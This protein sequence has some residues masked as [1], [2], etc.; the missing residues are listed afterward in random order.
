MQYF[1]AVG[2]AIQENAATKKKKVTQLIVQ[3]VKT[4]TLIATIIYYNNNHL[5]LASL[6]YQNLPM[7][8][9]EIF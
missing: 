3:R 8:Y 7:Q 4:Q 2:M 9:T 5:R 1:Y 6:H